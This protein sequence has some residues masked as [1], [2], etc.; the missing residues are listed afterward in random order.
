[1]GIGLACCRYSRFKDDDIGA[2]RGEGGICLN[3]PGGWLCAL[4]RKIGAFGL[5]DGRGGNGGALENVNASRIDT[6]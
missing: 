6:K 3:K 4:G 1:M 2:E 5:N